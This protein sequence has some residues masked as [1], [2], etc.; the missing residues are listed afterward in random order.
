MKCKEC[1]NDLVR[2]E[3]AV[4][5]ADSK[6]ISLQCPACGYME[7]EEKSSNKIIDGLKSKRIQMKDVEEKIVK[8]N[9]QQVGIYFDRE[10]A[11]RLSLKP[12]KTV[13]LSFPSKNKII[14]NLDR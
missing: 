11:E 6:V 5:D 2:V 8:M 13:R 10:T 1:G 12:G 14:V 3:V 7:F 4:E 9:D